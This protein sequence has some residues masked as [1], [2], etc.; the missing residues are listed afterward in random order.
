MI[1]ADNVCQGRIRANAEKDETQG[2]QNVALDLGTHPLFADCFCSSSW[3]VAVGI[4]ALVCCGVISSS[5]STT[6]IFHHEQCSSIYLGRRQKGWRERLILLLF[7]LLF[8]VLVDPG[9]FE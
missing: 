3:S 6:T 4:V 9:E 1:D 2:E 7:V 5:R 8:R